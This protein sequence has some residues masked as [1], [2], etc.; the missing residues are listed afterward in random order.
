MLKITIDKY[1]KENTRIK[2]DV[3]EFKNC[4]T[5]NDLLLRFV[6][7]TGTDEIYGCDIVNYRIEAFDKGWL[8]GE[9]TAYQVQMVL[10]G[11]SKMFKIRFYIDKNFEVNLD[12]D[13]Y[14]VKKFVEC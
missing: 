14:T 8:Y 12:P 10:D 1:F 3:A 13:L 9:V 11:Y 2:E 5:L 6:D 4:Y 7:E